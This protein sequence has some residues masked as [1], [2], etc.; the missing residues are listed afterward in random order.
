MFS[1]LLKRFIQ[2]IFVLWGISTIVFFME[3]FIPGSPADSILGVDAPDVDKI[4]WLARYGFDKPLY[5]QYILFLKNLVEGDLG[6]SYATAAN[7]TEIILPRLM[8]TL[9]LASVAFIFSVLLATFFGLL[10]AA[11]N[12]KSIDKLTAIFS[13]L[14][15]SAPSFIIGPILMW[16]FSVKLNVFPLMGNLSVSS[17]V[18]PSITLGSSLAAFSSRMIRSGLVDVLG[19]DYI[20]TAKSKGL[21]NSAVL[22]HHALRNAFLPA[23]TVLGMQLGVLLSGTIITEQIFNWPGLGSLVLEAVQQR[24]YNIISGCVMI[25]AVIYVL[26]NLAVDILYRIFDPRVRAT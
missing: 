11:N 21:S 1:T 18:L 13:L 7:V 26:C 23:L 8:E 12:G 10:S 9:R 19:E 20:R 6:K 3:R 24:E 25:M 17:F 16:L 22:I 2:L 14:A 15:I 4:A 5:E